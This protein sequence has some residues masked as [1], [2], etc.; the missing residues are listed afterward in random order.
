MRSMAGVAAL[1]ALF[2]LAACKKEPDFDARYD[3]AAANI[4]ERAAAIDAEMAN[5]TAR[6]NDTTSAASEDTR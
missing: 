5:Q 6:A 1:I 4:Q 3:A 2:A